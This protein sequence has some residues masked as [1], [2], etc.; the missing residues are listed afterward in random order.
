MEL[1]TLADELRQGNAWRYLN[2]E[3]VARIGSK[4]KEDATDWELVEAAATCEACEC[5]A[6][7]DQIK[8]AVAKATDAKSFWLIIEEV[9][10]HDEDCIAGQ[11]EATEPLSLYP[12]TPEEALK[13]ALG[14]PQGRAGEPLM[15]QHL[16]AEEANRRQPGA[17]CSNCGRSAADAPPSQTW[18]YNNGQL[19]CPSCARSHGV[20][21]R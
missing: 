11:Y 3:L 21:D 4:T 7:D 17:S 16:S 18:T 14:A 2:G 13:R 6:T 10:E 20:D 9:V 5:S 15:L 1:K 19:F 8:A 12:L